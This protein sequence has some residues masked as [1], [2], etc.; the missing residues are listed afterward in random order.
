[1]SMNYVK[2]LGVSELNIDRT[3]WGVLKT[4]LDLSAAQISNLTG[5]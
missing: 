5:R 2:K 1:M 3:T 4:R